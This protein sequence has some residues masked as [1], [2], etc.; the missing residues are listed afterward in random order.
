MWGE[1]LQAAK[2]G[3]GLFELGEEAFFGLKLARVDAAAASLHA[4]G[5]LQVKHL[6]VQQIFD[7]AARRVRAVEDAADHDGVVRGVVV[8]Q[9]AAGVVGAPGEHGL[10]QKT[11]EEARVQRVEDLVEVVVVA[12]GGEDALAAAGLPDVLGLA[13]DGLGGDV[14]AVAVGVLG[15]D[16]LLVKLRQKNVRDGVV[17]AL[18]S[19]LQQVREP[20]VQAALAQADRC[21]ERGEAAEADVE[22]W[23]GGARAKLAVLGLEDGDEGLWG[24]GVR[25]RLLRGRGNE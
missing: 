11:V 13:G 9:H 8:A 25:A 15:R 6:V 21:I 1:P 16:G 12:D 24:D 7:G 18:R 5:V 19:V 23:N 14:A 10:A 17:D 4:D 22:R 2:V 3:L 20:D